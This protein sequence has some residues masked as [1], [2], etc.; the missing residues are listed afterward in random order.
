[1]NIINEN[2]F[3]FTIKYSKKEDDYYLNSEYIVESD[4]K[5][6][7]VYKITSLAKKVQSVLYKIRSKKIIINIIFNNNEIEEQIA[8]WINLY[9]RYED[10]NHK[11][12]KIQ[13][14]KFNNSSCKEIELR[15]NKDY[16][17][18]HDF[19][20]NLNRP[21]SDINPSNFTTLVKSTLKKYNIPH[22]ITEYICD[23][24]SRFSAIYSVGKSGQHMP[25]MIVI[26]IN[27]ENNT[28]ACLI[29]K[30]ITF[31]TGGVNVKPYKYMLGM[32]KDKAGALFSLYLA[33]LCYLKYKI[34]NTVI[35]AVAENK[36]NSK[37]LCPMDIV[38]NYS[39]KFIRI[40]HTDAEGRVVLSDCISYACEHVNFKNLFTFATLT[41]TAECILGPDTSVFMSNNKA[42]S[43][44]IF[45]CSKNC[46]ERVVELP[47]DNWLKQFIKFSEN[48]ISGVKNCTLDSHADTAL[49]GMFLYEF[50][51]KDANFTHVDIAPLFDNSLL[52]SH[53]SAYCLLLYAEVIRE[54]NL[55]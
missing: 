33:I 39:N 25:R 51:S 50:F 19:Y 13:N 31:D 1:M 53:S 5:S 52:S 55:V 42:I 40:D 20:K 12:P 29:G 54:S 26:N 44:I 37:A 17:I 35:L 46:G 22:N 45:N 41:G 36:I 16:N 3:I 6:L 32:H 43:N 18:I 38:K 47:L 4:I 27:G 14:I 34:G 8:N 28:K 49:A 23:E 7:D 24:S 30:G 11:E 15:D 10:L 9:V 21:N 2:E 48:G